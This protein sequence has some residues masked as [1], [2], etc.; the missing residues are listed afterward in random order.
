MVTVLFPL[1]L[2]LSYGCT[3]IVN[4]F[5][6]ALSLL[7]SVNFLVVS[8]WK[9]VFEN[10]SLIISAWQEHPA[11]DTVGCPSQHRQHGQQQYIP[12]EARQGLC[13]CWSQAHSRGL[14]WVQRSREGRKLRRRFASC[15][16]LDGPCGLAVNETEFCKREIGWHIFGIVFGGLGFGPKW[17]DWVCEKSVEESVKVVRFSHE[18]M[19]VHKQTCLQACMHLHM[20]NRISCVCVWMC[21]CT[22]MRSHN[23]TRAHKGWYLVQNM[24]ASICAVA[25]IAQKKRVKTIFWF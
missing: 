5:S 9:W 15:V 19:Y 3:V 1:S 17:F 14:R 8:C 25:F 16:G 18:C 21:T 20:H 6:V 24:P 12:G 22:H 7:L 23:H 13:L 10:C 2:L 4:A 11:G